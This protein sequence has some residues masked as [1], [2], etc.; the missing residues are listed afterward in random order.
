MHVLVCVQGHSTN[1]SFRELEKKTKHRDH[2]PQA[3]YTDRASAACR[4][5]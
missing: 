1:I 5:T 2:S 3:N 4:R